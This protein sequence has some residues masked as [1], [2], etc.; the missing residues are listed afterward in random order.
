MGIVC[1]RCSHQGAVG[2]GQTVYVS[3]VLMP[4]FIGAGG[5]KM[6]RHVHGIVRGAA[7]RIFIFIGCAVAIGIDQRHHLDKTVSCIEHLDV[8]N[9]GRIAT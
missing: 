7:R 6:E 1:Q 4:A 5:F 2:D 9:V 8:Q 3:Y